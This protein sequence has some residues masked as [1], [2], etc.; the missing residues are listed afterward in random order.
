MIPETTEAE[1]KRLIDSALQETP[2]WEWRLYD[3]RGEVFI[4]HLA[5]MTPERWILYRDYYTHAP[6]APL[7]RPQTGTILWY[8]KGGAFGALVIGVIVGIV[9][10]YNV[11]QEWLLAVLVLVGIMLWGLDRLTRKTT[12]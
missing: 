4:F 10:G 9:D 7:E 6:T 3:P 1:I 11:P 2:K 5:D 8:A 12:P